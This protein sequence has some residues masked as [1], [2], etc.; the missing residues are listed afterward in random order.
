MDP[1]ERGRIGVIIGQATT[2]IM[3]QL[4]ARLELSAS[5]SGADELATIAALQM[6]FIAGAKAAR[7]DPGIADWELPWGDQWA[8]QHGQDGV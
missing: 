5:L 1:S 3:Q 2:P 6:A 4:V 8:K 7:S